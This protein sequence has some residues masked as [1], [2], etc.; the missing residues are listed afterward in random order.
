MPRIA[1]I[2][3]GPAGSVFAARMAQ[4][5]HDVVLY[6]RSVFPRPHLG[7]SLSAGVLPLLDAVG[8]RET[9]V[10]AGFAPVRDIRVQWDTPPYLRNDP[11]A[12]GLLVDRGRF[13]AILL[14][15]ARAHGV[16]IKQPALVRGYRS[17]DNGVAIEVDSAGDR[18]L[19]TADFVADVRGRGGVSA[20]RRRTGRPTI[21][22]YAYWRTAEPP[23]H[24]SIEAGAAG[25]FWGV[26][27][28]D[29]TYNTL[30]FL[31]AHAFHARARGSLDQCFRELLARSSLMLECPDAQMIGRVQAIDAT[32]YID[33][34]V[35][36]STIRLGDAALAIDPISSS[37]VQKAIQNALS[38]AIVVNTIL[39][40]PDAFSAA[41][42]FYRTNLGAASARH[43]S[44]AAGHYGTV[45]M[46]RPDG[47][48]HARA[49]SADTPP[50]PERVTVD[51]RSLTAM[52][53][54]RSAAT[55]LIEMPCLDAEFV[56][57][58][59]ALRHPRL[60]NPVAFVGGRAVAPL[61]WQLPA[62]L[63]PM[64]IARAWSQGRPI[65]TTLAIIVWLIQHGV[66][67]PQA[68]SNAA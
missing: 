15:N 11:A 52:R 48:W 25:W 55:E 53:I 54:R 19:A 50:L 41:S 65:E 3:G 68:L 51:A 30:A 44:W 49:A 20:T 18:Q 59:P 39:R 4:L 43:S 2:G 67:E 21:A 29:G 37:G 62:G 42:A 57:V 1:V 8:A 7:E 40:R 35:T 38:G 34:A 46:T 6:E 26:P 32:P 33:D 27:L 23:R 12:R 14:D 66:L 64:E 17:V 28:P 9:V 10:T 45:A 47:F 31:D 36:K 60:E 61:V 63:T 56:T 24:P 22:L 58:K 5:G 13:D 16:Q